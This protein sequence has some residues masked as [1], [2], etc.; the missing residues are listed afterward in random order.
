MKTM[1]SLIVLN[2]YQKTNKSL[3]I[4]VL[5]VVGVGEPKGTSKNC[6]L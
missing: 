6:R 1:K 5:E 3:L 4:I 2:P